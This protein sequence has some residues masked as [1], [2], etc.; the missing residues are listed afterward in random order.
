MLNI[1]LSILLKV[2]IISGLLL[3]DPSLGTENIITS[4]DKISKIYEDTKN[5]IVSDCVTYRLTQF[6]YLRFN[7]DQSFQLKF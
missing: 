5:F 2:S 7:L 4:V 6:H 1:I 3:S